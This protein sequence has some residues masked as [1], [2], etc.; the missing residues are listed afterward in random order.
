ML[1][2]IMI[3]RKNPIKLGCFWHQKILIRSQK[4][5]PIELR[6]RSQ[7]RLQH[8]HPKSERRTE[9]SGFLTFVFR[10]LARIQHFLGGNIIRDEVTIKFRE[11]S[12]SQMC[13]RIVHDF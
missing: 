6:M 5:Y 7:V 1:G 11:R 12:G 4:L 10:R 3:N 9:S 8:I 13:A 2:I